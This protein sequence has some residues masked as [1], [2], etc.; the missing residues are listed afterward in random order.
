M[1]QLPA[2]RGHRPPGAK[3]AQ[4]CV[5]RVVSVSG[6][7]RKTEDKLI[8]LDKQMIQLAKDGQKYSGLDSLLTAERGSGAGHMLR[9]SGDEDEVDTMDED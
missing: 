4:H 8:I 1:T 2:P 3:P 9:D 6:T 7:I 5:Y